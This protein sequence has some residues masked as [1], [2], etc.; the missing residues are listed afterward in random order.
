MTYATGGALRDQCPTDLLEGLFTHVANLDPELIGNLVGA[1]LDHDATDVLPTISVPT[2]ILSGDR[3]QLTPVATAE[4][5]QRAIPG[6]ELVVFPGHTHLV[7]VEQPHAVHAA[8]D[9]F[10]RTRGL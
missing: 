7:Q 3:D 4:R 2:L 10:L 1:Y 8:I 5:M 6:S 9:A